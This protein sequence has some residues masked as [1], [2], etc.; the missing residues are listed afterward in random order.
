[1]SPFIER[2]GWVLIHS[3]WQLAV[4]AAA[5]FVVHRAMQRTSAAAR[6][7]VLLA[8]LGLLVAAPLVTWSLL[9][10]PEAI[11]AP[12]PT[13]MLPEPV[14]APA[15]KVEAVAPAVAPIPVVIPSAPPIVPITPAPVVA[16]LPAA[17]PEPVQPSWSEWAQQV[18]TP[19]LSTIVWGWSLGVLAF[20]IRPLWSWFTVRQLRTQ[21]V[22]PVPESVQAALAET[23]RR[24]GMTQAVRVLQSTIVQVPIVAGY[25]K[26][27]IL[28]PASI[29][30][31][32]PASQLEAILAHELAHIRR[33]DYL[34][35]LLQTLVET[36]FFYHPAVWWLSHQIR[37]ERENCCDDI[38][39]SALGSRLDYSRAL[40]ALEEIRVAQTP[41]AVG[42]SG[43]SLVGRVRRLFHRDLDQSSLSSGNVALGATLIVGVLSIAAIAG[44]R[45]ADT[46]D[47]EVTFASPTANAT[48][49]PQLGGSASHN[50]A[51]P[52]TN[53]P[54]QF[55]L[56]KNE[57]I[58]WSQPIGDFAFSSPVVSG[59]KVLI[60]TNNAIGRDPRFPASID[61]ACLQCFD[62]RTGEFLWQ[63]SSPRM[64]QGRRHDW[65]AI[66]ICST[67]V[68]EG[69]RVWF[70]TNRCEIVCLDLN[71]HRDNEGDGEPEASAPEEAGA[72]NTLT[73]SP[74]PGG[75]GEPEMQRADVVWKYDMFNTLGVRPLNATCVTPTIAGDLLLLNSGNDVDE[76]YQTVPAPEA[77]AFL[78]FHKTTGQLIWSD[79]TPNPNILGNGCSMGAPAVA[80]IDGVWQAIFAGY[81]GWL[82]AFDLES[83]QRSETLLLWK[84]DLNPKESQYRLSGPRNEFSYRGL[85]STP[86]VVGNHVYA[87]VGHNPERGE[88]LGRLWCIDA[89]QRGDLSSDLVYNKS[90]P[91]VVIPHKRAQACEPYKGD[92]TRPN[93]NSGVEWVYTTDDLNK[94]GQIEFEEQMHLS[95]SLPAI[96]DGLL[97]TTDLSGLVH[98]LDATTGELLW[99]HDQLATCWSGPLLADGKAWVIDEDGDLSIFALSRDK[100]LLAEIAMNSPGYTNVAAANQTLYVATKTQLVAIGSGRFPQPDG[101]T[102]KLSGG[103][104]IELV[105]VTPNA[106]PTSEGWRAD[107]S[108]IEGAGNWPRGATFSKDG[109]RFTITTDRTSKLPPDP[110]ARDLLFES[111]GL[112]SHPSWVILNQKG[113]TQF[114]SVNADEA[115]R[116]R[117]SYLPKESGQPLTVEMALTD[118]PWG[119]WQRIDK[120]GKRINTIETFEPDQKLYED[121]KFLRF[122]PALEGNAQRPLELV[123]DEPATHDGYQSGVFDITVR[124]IGTD[125]KV[126]TTYAQPQPRQNGRRQVAWRTGGDVPLEKIDHVEFRLRPYRHFITFKNVPLDR[127]PGAQ[128]AVEH[129]SLPLPPQ[130]VPDP[131]FTAQVPGGV[132][133]ELLR[134]VRNDL[135]EDL[136]WT[137][138]GMPSPGRLD[139]PQRSHYKVQP[140]GNGYSSSNEGP[141]SDRAWDF[142]YEVRSAG[143]KPFVSVDVVGEGSTSSSQF[144]PAIGPRL[145]TVLPKVPESLTAF[146]LR[147]GTE[148]W[149]EWI[150]VGADGEILNPEA[151]SKSPN[152]PEKLVTVAGAGLDAENLDRSWIKWLAPPNGGEY[153][154]MEVRAIDD[155]G[156]IVES[157][158]SSTGSRETTKSFELP[159]DRLARFEYRL[160]PYRHF[161]RFD[162]ICTDPKKPTEVKVTVDPIV[163]PEEVVEHSDSKT[164]QLQL[165]N[166]NGTLWQGSLIKGHVGFTAPDAKAWNAWVGKDRQA[167][168]SALPAGKHWLISRFPWSVIP[169][170]TPL[171]QPLR[172]PL[173]LSTPPKQHSSSNYS[174]NLSIQRDDQGR[175]FIHCDLFN[176]TDELWSFSELDLTL[177]AGW[178]TTE[179]H[180][181]SPQWL[182]DTLTEVPQIEIPPGQKGS[183]RINW[184]EWAQRGVWDPMSGPQATSKP[185]LPEQQPGQIWVRI[186]GPGFGTESIAVMHP[187]K[188]LAAGDEPTPQPPASEDQPPHVELIGLTRD[189]VPKLDTWQPNGSPIQTPE[190]V[191]ELPKLVTEDQGPPSQLFLYEIDGVRS[192]PSI[193]YSHKTA[194]VAG[195]SELPEGQAFRQAV[196]YHELQ[197]ISGPPLWGDPPSVLLSD[198]PW[199]PWRTVTKDGQLAEPLSNDE[200]YSL[201]YERFTFHGV[202]QLTRA[203]DDPAPPEHTMAVVQQQLSEVSRQYAIEIQSVTQGKGTEASRYETITPRWARNVNP[204]QKPT[205]EL[206][207]PFNPAKT[208]YIRFRI[209]PYRHQFVFENVNYAPSQRPENYTAFKVVTKKLEHDLP[210]P[211]AVQT[212]S[213]SILPSEPGKDFQVR[214]GVDRSRTPPE[215]VQ[216]IDG[217]VRIIMENSPMR[218]NGQLESTHVEL[219][220]N[221]AVIWTPEAEPTSI[222]KDGKIKADSPFQIYLEGEVRAQLGKDAV[223]DSNAFYYF[224]GQLGTFFGIEPTTNELR[225]QPLWARAGAVRKNVAAKFSA[226]ELSKKVVAILTGG[227]ELELLGVTPYREP[228][229]ESWTPY[230]KKFEPAPEWGS[231]LTVEP[232]PPGV[233]DFSDW[234]NE[235][236]R[237]FIVRVRG[238]T[239][240]QRALLPFSGPTMESGDSTIGPMSVL[241]WN[242]QVQ[243]LRIGL[244]GEWGPYRVLTVDL[245]VPPKA[246][247]VNPPGE[248]PAPY[249]K[250]YDSIQLRLEAS[251]AREERWGKPPMK[252]LPP[253]FKPGDPDPDFEPGSRVRLVWKGIPTNPDLKYAT[254]EAVVI[255][256]EGKPH[257]VTAT[258]AFIEPEGGHQWDVDIFDVPI[259][260]VSHIEYRLR[261]YQHVVTF[262]NVALKPGVACGPNVVVESP[263]SPPPYVA[264]PARPQRPIES[265]EK[266]G[267][268]C[269]KF[270]EEVPQGLAGERMGPTLETSGHESDDGPLVLGLRVAKVPNWRIGGQVRVELTVRNQSKKEV[271]FTHTGRSDNGLSVVAIDQNGKE[272]HAD[273]AQFDSLLVF[274]PKMLPPFHTT[275]V[276]SFLLR[277]DSEKRDVSDPG[278]AAFHLPPGDYKLQ[279]RWNDAQSEVAHEGEWT[280]ELTSVAHAFH[281]AAA[282]EPPGQPPGPKDPTASSELIRKLS[283]PEQSERDQ[284]A[285]QLK[286]LFKRSAK[287]LWQA[288]IDAIPKGTP[289]AEVFATLGIDEKR[290]LYGSIDSMEQYRLDDTWMARIW[291]TEDFQKL[292]TIELLEQLNGPWV[293]PPTDFTGTWVTYY[294]NGE[295]AQEIEYR[296][297]KY[298]GRHRSYHSNGKL[299]VQQHY[300]DHVANGEDTGYYSSG[301]LMYR[302]LY[303]DDKQV[304]PWIHYHEDGS[305]RSRTEHPQPTRP[306][307]SGMLLSEIRVVA[308]ATNQPV[309]GGKVTVRWSFDRHALEVSRKPVR[310]VFDFQEEFNLTE[311][312][313]FPI[314][315]PVGMEDAKL[316]LQESVRHPDYVIEQSFGAWQ[317]TPEMAADPALLKAKLFAGQPIKLKRGYEVSGLVADGLGQPIAGVRVYAAMQMPEYLNMPPHAVTDTQGRYKF[318]VPDHDGYQLMFVPADRDKSAAKTDKPADLTT[319]AQTNLVAQS[320]PIRKEYGE[321]PVVKLQPGTRIAGVVRAAAGQPLPNIVVQA[322]DDDS[323]YMGFPNVMSRVVTDAEGR[324][325]LPAQKLPVDVRIARHNQLGGW[326][327]PASIPADVY[328]PE[329]VTERWGKLRI[330]DENVYEVD[331]APV[332]TVTLRARAYNAKGQPDADAEIELV[333]NV[334]VPGAGPDQRLPQW[335]R[336]FT[337][338][339]GEVGLYELM[340]PQ[341]L[342]DARIDLT[343]EGLREPTVGTWTRA[344]REEE[345]LADPRTKAAWPVLDRDDDSIIIGEPAAVA[346]NPPG[347][348]ASGSNTDKSATAR[349]LPLGAW[350][351]TVGGLRLRLRMLRS[352]QGDLPDQTVG[353]PVVM[354]LEVENHSDKP[355]EISSSSVFSF[356]ALQIIGPD[357]QPC[358]DVRGP[359]STLNRPHSI[360]SGKIGALV[361]G[362]DIADQFLM[363]Q[364]GEYIVQATIR[365]GTAELSPG[366][367]RL[368]LKDGPVTPIR[369]VYR[370]MLSKA[371]AGSLVVLVKDQLWIFPSGQFK[372]A[373]P[374]GNPVVKLWHSPTPLD[375]DGEFPRD[376]REVGGFG[377]TEGAGHWYAEI[378]NE[379]QGQWENAQQD[380]LNVCAGLPGMPGER[381]P[382]D[383]TTSEKVE[384]IL[385]LGVWGV[386]V[387]ADEVRALGV[388][389]TPPV[390]GGVRVTAIEPG[391]YI[392]SQI[393]SGKLQFAVGDVIHSVAA[394]DVTSTKDVSRNILA[395]RREGHSGFFIGT[396]SPTGHGRFNVEF[397]EL[398]TDPQTGQLKLPPLEFHIV[399]A[400]AVKDP[401]DEAG[402]AW[403]PIGGDFSPKRY[404]SAHKNWDHIKTPVEKTVDDKRLGLVGDSTATSIPWDGSWYVEKCELS[405]DPN[406]PNQFQIDVTVDSHGG[407]LLRKLT[408]DHLGERLAVVVEERIV[409][410]PT[411]RSEFGNRFSITGHLTKA[412]GEQLVQAIRRGMNPAVSG[413]G[414][415]DPQTPWRAKGRVVDG[416]GKPLSG[417]T[418]RAATGI[419]TLLGGGSGTTDADGRYDFRFGLGIRMAKSADGKPSPQTQ[420]ALISAQ[421]E[422]HFEKNFNRQG[423][424]IGS[425]EPVTDEVAK[426]YGVEPN[427]I[428]LPNRPREVDFVM[429]P[430]AHVAGTL[431]GE[432]DR[433][434]KDYSVMLTGDTLPPGSEVI[435]QVKTDEKGRFEI[436][437]IPT[438]VPF[439]FEIRKPTAELMP[440][441]EDTWASRPYLF[442]DPGDND[443]SWSVPENRGASVKSLRIRVQGSGVEGKKA[444]SQAK[445]RFQLIQKQNQLRQRLIDPTER[446][447]ERRE[448]E[449][450]VLTIDLSNQFSP[451]EEPAPDLKGSIPPPDSSPNRSR[452][453]VEKQILSIFT[454]EPR[455]ELEPLQPQMAAASHALRIDVAL[456]GIPEREQVIEIFESWLRI[457]SDPNQQ[458]IAAQFLAQNAPGVAL[459]LIRESVRGETKQSAVLTR[460]DTINMARLLGLRAKEVLPEFI[461]L[462]NELATSGRYDRSLLMA[463]PQLGPDSPEVAAAVASL[464][465][466][467]NKYPDSYIVHE[468]LI[469]LALFG[470]LAKPHV[471][472]FETRID[473]N[474][475]QIKAAAAFGLVTTGHDPERGL[476]VLIQLVPT[477]PDDAINLLGILGEL[478]KPVLQELKQTQDQIPD[479]SIQR[480]ERTVQ[481]IEYGRPFLTHE[482]EALLGM[483]L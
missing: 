408:A 249:R 116:R 463:L 419:G 309:T 243:R 247:A 141:G 111:R 223:T 370:S 22:S 229:Q 132:E 355:A 172:L 383:G 138:D 94:N 125:Q 357:G 42:A 144:L 324:Y 288:K 224:D 198:E 325:E 361:E 208:D 351:D 391:G 45:P 374:G 295:K 318:R 433:P 217:G 241:T 168:L 410:A 298:H 264:K 207:W 220:A 33:H 246:K 330:G 263:P 378:P 19:W 85:P 367:L 278:V 61:R 255:D 152:S 254:H 407:D 91:E 423:N 481:Q 316:H 3:L 434:L 35:N 327:E 268:H 377:A 219:S 154:Q 158:S 41:L 338:V 472:I 69:D 48:S 92:F 380:I 315:I 435:A 128:V 38:A 467:L 282:D 147:V 68:I 358:L 14:P 204:S 244:P 24:L 157:R 167:D 266:V 65:P 228:G 299:L 101:V 106:A 415:V 44:T 151:M 304:G 364:P 269:Q 252:S 23:A 335:R 382:S 145:V 87:A 80:K 216:A 405:A 177:E 277:F 37:C 460:E 421:L 200:T 319:L 176:N 275:T 1:M 99:T 127:T 98:C 365:V 362:E 9:P 396:A 225:D 28:L 72:A 218:F 279:C 95:N 17:I 363:T 394:R 155:D 458:T 296:N 388:T 78:A 294:V 347:A 397:S 114:E 308:A 476:R 455:E 211:I 59:G 236:Y 153:Y 258:S 482:L 256:L 134:I 292:N 181:H 387:S 300:T 417:V 70:A 124:F 371:P 477:S 469:Q 235:D 368:T 131:R 466:S 271:L 2:L 173:R 412:E 480:W 103:L 203:A 429:L 437:E 89:T 163:Y 401:V 135:P 446:Q 431:V 242:Q 257:G 63:Y 369:R 307:T 96:H 478:A 64:E 322:N 317:V 130:H 260:Q 105:G 413:T 348:D 230:G 425:L 162:Q 188:L 261:P 74:S 226:T 424:G 6:Y 189:T 470:E 25:L 306:K 166:P 301:Q 461:Q 202:R 414:E 170:E 334:S 148:P 8:M 234:V 468:A 240:E 73:P 102:A 10:V 336:T 356:G 321:H 221:R 161:V 213:L 156:K 390:P 403:F 133:I 341:G 344:A 272:H 354:T 11:S 165:Q 473:S 290:D 448:T 438:T 192:R 32:L 47:S 194:F 359:H 209:R 366:E 136:S 349:E 436:K 302:G 46:P 126:W 180:G 139:W 459:R 30:T 186:S 372:S 84:F 265:Y 449:L 454:A 81:D 353:T 297:G 381:A 422:G 122:G 53:L 320:I 29:V 50:P 402:H 100:Q 284:A 465:K 75:R 471:Q 340:A 149:G 411:I 90:A 286:T 34:V 430:A 13:A 392:D 190:W 16:S 237:D 293:D 342:L 426:Q 352:P 201:G 331:F 398:L 86:V 404:E 310:N 326:S 285:A 112:R 4:L 54:T 215:S 427:Q 251:D 239:P 222:A 389:R 77:P 160:R 109:E 52:V 146:Q 82:Y 432:D 164:S 450:N 7:A 337:A 184:P 5:A 373:D 443:M 205:V 289:R 182:G 400:N 375:A 121:I 314:R 475:N 483:K 376:V 58:R 287:E 196:L 345:K 453:E 273:I 283:A 259:S 323:V 113:W 79:K 253:D 233:I 62:E 199:G 140:D 440:P 420:S 193:F 339:P 343:G 97:L 179:S 291:F 393:Q 169:V 328:L 312:G 104:E 20:A 276:K 227:L 444:I 399:A 115:I 191:R 108:L 197:N 210:K 76:S 51:S 350:G 238:F 231:R 117:L 479:K 49:W 441:W 416:D 262:N 250:V 137:P 274:L 15:P 118:S 39:V 36:V 346:L 214:I 474:D 187:D 71:G 83:I 171:Q 195:D 88:G 457:G 456:R 31:G 123:L 175:E 333:A 110:L 232:M 270:H 280:G 452:E 67:P 183:L 462:A 447:R 178:F 174:A 360:Q 159:L 206:I 451:H 185:V 26:P 395:T 248:V 385:E 464:V 281:L 418:V 55:D 120:S 129:R 43:G 107:G 56:T 267:V 150:Q 305:E 313:T 40:L 21:G 311:Q 303:E 245:K 445:S 27:V 119:P 329:F 439:Q 386:S 406:N 143:S 428:V 60:G 384:P 12:E 93:P 442:R 66:G 379:V 212:R 142:A 18:I 57:S 409:L 332:K